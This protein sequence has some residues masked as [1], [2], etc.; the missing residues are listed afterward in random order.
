MF[1]DDAQANVD[2]A[3]AIGWDAFLYRDAA[4]CAAELAGRG[5][6]A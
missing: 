5:L 4:Q 3:R 1:V 2:A 6:P